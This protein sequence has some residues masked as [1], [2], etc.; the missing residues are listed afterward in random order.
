M[1][2]C[3]ALRPGKEL[4]EGAKVRGMREFREALEGMLRKQEHLVRGGGWRLFERFYYL[5]R[6]MEGR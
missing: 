6:E 2:Q 1:L 3:L 5:K 4:P